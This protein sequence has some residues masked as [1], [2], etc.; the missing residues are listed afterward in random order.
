MLFYVRDRK[1]IAPKK[2]IDGIHKENLKANGIGNNTSPGQ[3]LKGNLQNCQTQNG[4]YNPE[5]SVSKS[6]INSELSKEAAVKEASSQLTNKQ[7]LVEK[8][9]KKDALSEPSQNMSV[10][11][12]PSEIRA[13]LKSGQG[14]KL[15]RSAPSVDINSD[16]SSNGKAVTASIANISNSKENGSAK[17]I[18]EFLVPNL[19]CCNGSHNS[20]TD[21]T[22]ENDASQKVNGCLNLSLDF[23]PAVLLLGWMYAI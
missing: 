20:A 14:E 5:S 7:I 11:K 3:R 22:T 15:Q 9:S 17:N 18:S 10:V 19:P 23:C 16:V 21:L 12:A 13:L 1:N 2:S 8:S 6:A 4:V